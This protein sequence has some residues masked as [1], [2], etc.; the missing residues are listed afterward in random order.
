MYKGQLPF[1]SKEGKLRN[2]ASHGRTRAWTAALLRRNEPSTP[3]TNLGVLPSQGD[4]QDLTVGKLVQT[5]SPLCML[6][7]AI[8]DLVSRL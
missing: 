4:S 6:A 8:E 7:S 2:N 1:V 5:T 3:F